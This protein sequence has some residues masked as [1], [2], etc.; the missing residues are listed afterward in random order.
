VRA[1]AVDHGLHAAVEVGADAVH[2]VDVGDPRNPVLVS[3]TPH[4]LRLRLDAGDGVKQRDRAVEHAQRPLNLDGE[5]DVARRV[6][7]VD[8]VALPVCGGRG[9][10]DRDAALLLLL[11]PVHHRS[12]LVNLPHLVGPAGVI[13]DALSRRRLT[14]VDVSHDSDVASVFERESAGHLRQLVKVEEKIDR[15]HEKGPTGAPSRRV[16]RCGALSMRSASPSI[17]YSVLG[18]THG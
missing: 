2:L 15:G 4:R 18:G 11:H 17:E 13:E 3:L 8:A 5:V 9:R 7:D 12:A 10:G 16:C 6:D 14:G 1:Q